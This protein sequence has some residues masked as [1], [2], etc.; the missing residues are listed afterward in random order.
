MKCP[1]CQLENR[2]GAKFCNECGHR[3]E[4]KCPECGTSNRPGSKFCDECGNTLILPVKQ[5]TKD[6]TF[7]EKLDKIQRYLPKGLTEKILAQRDRIEGERKL[8]TVMFCDMEG[9]TTLSERIGPEE[10]YSV[11]DQVYEILIHKVHDYEGTVNEMAGDGIMALFGA[12]IA[13]EDAPQRAIRSAYA[14]HREMTRFS[15]KLR[16]EKSLPLIRMRIGI[17]TGPV[18]VGTLGN[19]LRVEFKAVGDTVNLASRVEGLADPGATYVTEDTYKLTEG[20]F[21]FESIGKREVKGREKPIKVYRVIAPSTRRTRFDVSAERG[22]TPL[23]GRERELEILLDCYEM[24]KQG[25]GQAV[26]IV[27]E[28]GLG[29]SRLLYEFRKAI[30]NEEATFVEGRCYSYARN[31]PYHAVI[32]SLKSNFGIQD[33]DGDIETREKIEIGLKLVGADEASTIPY[34]LELFSV[35]DSGVDN[36]SLSPKARKDRTIEALNRNV[37]MGS[38]IRPVVMAVEDLHWIDKSSEERFQSLLDCISGAR[39]FLIFTYRPEFVHTWGGKSY[40]SQVNLN[41]LS[42]RES[43]IML[44]HLLR[45]EDLDKKLEN[46]TL[47]KTEGIP[48]FIEEFVKSLVDLKIIKN[49]NNRCYLARGIKEAIIPAKIQDVIT[50][51]VDSL[52]EGAKGVIQIGAVIGREFSHELIKNVADFQE[53]ELLSYL[54]ILRDSEL[55]YERGVYP[56]STYIF[57][58]A[59]IQEVAYH[60]LIKT[61]RQR[62]HQRIA[63]VLEERFPEATEN[64][65]E[66]LAYHCTEA[67]LNEKAVAYWHTAGQK[68][69]ERSANAEAIAHIR[70]GLEVLQ[71]NPDMPEHTR[72]EVSLQIILGQALIATRGQAASEVGDAY[73]R[74]RKLCQ[75]AEDVPRLFRVLHGLWHFHASRGEVLTIRELSEELHTLAQDIQ[76]PSY[77]LCAHFALGSAL[78]LQG[79][80]I[81]ANEQWKQSII[82]YNPQKHHSDTFLFGFDLGMFSL[83]FAPHAL[84]HLG[85][86]DQAGAMSNKALAL[87]REFTHHFSLTVALAYRAMFCQF[88]R[89]RH[90]AHEC[91]D[92]LVALCAEQGSAYYLAW[93]TIIRGWALFEQGLVEEGVAQLHQ[94]LNALLSTG[95]KARKPYY[96]A[97]L[98][99]AYEKVGQTEEGLATVSEAIELVNKTEERWYEAE[100]HRL[101]GE[102]LLQLSSDNQTDVEACFHQALSIARNQQAKSLELRAAISLSRLWQIN[103]NQNKAR[104][105][106]GEVYGWFTEGFDTADLIEAKALL[107]DLF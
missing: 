54:S 22:L 10:A 80:F 66:L 38:E 91:A 32:D 71:M 77:L 31:V 93:G 52:S 103:G 8:V 85:Y 14:I 46:L 30:A 78:F 90:I 67:G 49:E 18:V 60:S 61:N 4:V 40:H 28:A 81:T 34:F 21:R 33:G 82:L 42:N 62:Y 69:I 6:L 59:L 27:A 100:L 107:D 20:M 73:D 105:L 89:E 44:Y 95:G 2:E 36:L 84:W 11:M 75:L 74:A 57:K 79:D 101:K 56:Q 45:T 3:F 88:A 55:I 58:H 96:L 26:S 70:E 25:R 94:G 17:H 1:K 48:F 47:A 16:Q 13:L 97:L 76:D 65:P 63:Q 86:P 102:L 83:C 98:A 39:V 12:P 99:E 9:F 7:D 53:Q 19:D 43:L 15:D 37:L 23:V 50:A 104:Q 51:R 64:Q 87:A 29:K 35:K 68:A 24:S 92:E 72:N 41:R 5:S 106:L